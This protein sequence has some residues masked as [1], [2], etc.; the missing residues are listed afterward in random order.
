MEEVQT[1]NNRTQEDILEISREL[2]EAYKDEEDYWQQKSRNMWHI[3]RNLN[4]NFYHALTK[5]LHARNKIVGS[6]ILMETG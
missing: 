2:Q 6:I 1:Y 5:Q 3:S 4:T